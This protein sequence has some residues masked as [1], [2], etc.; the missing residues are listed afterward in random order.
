MNKIRFLASDE[1]KKIA[2][3]EV[4]ERPANLV[5]ELVEN[6]IDAQAQEISIYI[7]D[8][9]KKLVRVVDNG[10]GMSFEDAKIAFQPHTTSKI[11]HVDDLQTLLTFG[12]R[13]E[14]LSSISS[15]S[16]ITLVT[17]ESTAEVGLKLKLSYGTIVAEDEVGCSDGTDI[18]IHDIFSNIPARKKFLKISDTEWRQIVLLFQAFVLAHKN[19]HFKL[20]HEDR[21]IHNCPPVDDIKMRVMQLWNQQCADHLL[22]L[23][24]SEKSID[25]KFEGAI[26]DH[27]YMRYNTAQIFLF[28]NGRWIRNQKLVKAVLRGYQNVYQQ[29]RYPAVFLFIKTDPSLIDVNIHPRKEEVQFIHA[30]KIEQLIQHHI[31]HTLNE[32][33][34]LQLRSAT[35]PDARSSFQPFPSMNA[36]NAEQKPKGSFNVS[37]EMPRNTFSFQPNRS[38]VQQS[39]IQI[40]I[41][42]EQKFIEE[43]RYRLIGQA[44]QTYILL[45]KDD[46]LLVIDQHAAHERILYELFKKRFEQIE[47]ITLMFPQAVVLD[48]SEMSLLVKYQPLLAQY[49][50]IGDQ[51][52]IDRFVVKSVPI[53]LK[54]ANLVELIKE[55]AAIIRENEHLD[56]ELFKKQL[57]ERMHAQMA[58]KAA[59]KAGD[60]LSVEKMQEI[61]NQL[62]LAENRLTCPHGRPTIWFLSLSEIEK[63]FRRDYIK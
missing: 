9:G 23:E 37:Q 29:G 4:V 39:D 63:R 49:G 7:E 43:N 30:H 19:I 31:A 1:I 34:T 13:G 27:Q 55:V 59:V 50:I 15:V 48:E 61:I 22:L 41:S 38:S 35:M 14:A 57:R 28:V 20:F 16:V 45:E 42:E 54:N 44:H 46:G 6:A 10:Y 5:K 26:S 36:F 11:T 8:G 56:E 47:T 17:K 24:A 2:A 58:C 60:E 51:M 53:Y 25:F 21:L 62:E 18:A 40:T 12:F 52:G 3:G 33:V 32:R